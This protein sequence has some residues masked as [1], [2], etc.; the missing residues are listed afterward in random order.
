MCVQTHTGCVSHFK[1][2]KPHLIIHIHLKWG[3]R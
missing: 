1:D 2:H 3:D